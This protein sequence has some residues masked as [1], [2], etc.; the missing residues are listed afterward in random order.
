M[1]LVLHPYKFNEHYYKEYELD[2]FE[3]KL[4]TNFEIHDLSKL[5]NPNWRKAFS[6]KVH[7]KVKT[8]NSIKEWQNYLYLLIREKKNITVL[9]NL[10][11]NTINSII[12]HYMLFKSRLNIIQYRSP[13]IPLIKRKQQTM[14]SFIFTNIFNLE[15][16]KISKLFFFLKV[17][18]FL[19]ISSIFKFEKVYILFSGKKK[20]FQLLLNS[21]KNIY[22]NIHSKDYSKFLINNKLKK[23]KTKKNN[24][25]VYFDLP[26][27][28]FFND[29]I[30]F[31]I[32]I[33]H[34]IK[35]WY[36]DLND[37]LNFVEKKFNLNVIII[38]HPKARGIVNPLYNKRFKVIRDIEGIT[39]L[40]P[41]SKFV[42][43]IG[44]S[45]ALGL[46]VANKKPIIILYNDQ[47]IKNDQYMFLHSQNMSKELGTS[48]VNINK[49]FDKNDL[50]LNIDYSRY[51]SYKYNYLTSKKLSKKMN[52]DIFNKIIT[53]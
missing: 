43:N 42:L 2:I 52:Y 8:F 23:K 40:I 17:K 21:K 26:G 39:Q 51:N 5:V 15:F 35:K 12:I 28:Y 45:T 19:K 3:K 1:L 38:P 9:N 36:K 13:S 31:G 14:I 22:T 24:Y 47:I 46:A 27:P 49:N 25:A 41:N 32:K 44:G 33:N 18:F 11:I 34:N 30:L 10:D 29:K 6:G 48:F 37:Y 50:N 4:S 53:N 7:K 20:N 16:L